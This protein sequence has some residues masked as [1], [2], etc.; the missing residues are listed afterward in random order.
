[1]KTN[2]ENVD[3]ESIQ[4]SNPLLYLT[5][6]LGLQQEESQETKKDAKAKANQRLQPVSFDLE[7]TNHRGSLKGD[8]T[9]QQSSKDTTKQTD[10][11]QPH[12]GASSKR[13]NYKQWLRSLEKSRS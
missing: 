2:L 3:E 4:E 6:S 5:I 13:A 12:M 11:A 10:P 9:L 8:V 7:P 1:M